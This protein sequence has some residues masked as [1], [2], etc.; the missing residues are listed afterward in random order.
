MA[1]IFEIPFLNPI[2]F[3]DY[4]LVPNVSL[5]SLEFD[6][7]FYCLKNPIEY[8]RQRYCAPFQQSD[9][10]NF[11]FKSIEA[12][13]GNFT[14]QVLDSNGSVYSTENITQLSGTYDGK[15]CY[16]ASIK[17]ATKAEGKYFIKVT[18]STGAMISEP[19][20]VRQYHPNTILIAYWNSYNSG[21]II[22]LNSIKFQKRIYG[23]I[24]ELTTDSAF[25][26]YEDQPRSLEMLSGTAFRKFKLSIG[27]RGQNVPEYEADKLER[28][29]MCDNVMID[30]K[31]YTREEGSKIERKENNKNPLSEYSL[32][33]RERINNDSLVANGSNNVVIATLPF[34]PLFYI[35]QVTIQGSVINPVSDGIFYGARNFVDWLNNVHQSN[36]DEFYLTLSDANELVIH[37]VGSYVLSGTNSLSSANVLE[38]GLRLAIQTDATNVDINV[39][40]SSPS[41]S[42]KIFYGDGT[43]TA[44][45]AIAGSPSATHTY[46]INSSFT[47]FVFCKDLNVIGFSSSDLIINKIFGALPAST[48]DFSANTVA[49]G[50]IENDIFYFLNGLFLSLDLFGNSIPSYN[51]M[52]II[53]NIY[54]ASIYGKISTGG[55]LLLFGQTPSAPPVINDEGTRQII[56]DLVNDYG[57]ITD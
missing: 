20:S 49:L 30:G 48:D 33:V 42:Y 1:M 18:H 53:M 15:K 34:T 21:N 10:I 47:C 56:A 19:I 37:A 52:Q 3:I 41:S 27:I 45:T 31:Y 57:L 38:Y 14:L 5:N 26:V 29:T 8:N 24:D 55:S 25:H 23:S 35:N 22:Y 11:Q 12:T 6:N 28:L 16:Q 17:L 4:S 32:S 40:F 46:A 13:T 7:G 39:D 9:C 36:I 44:I 50:E 54:D 2:R 43:T 51:I